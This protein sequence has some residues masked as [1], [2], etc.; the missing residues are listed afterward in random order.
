MHRVDEAEH[1]S[2]ER[3]RVE[4]ELYDVAAR[5]VRAGR[6]MTQRTDEVATNLHEPDGVIAVSNTSV[7]LKEPSRFAGPQPRTPVERVVLRAL[8]VDELDFRA[9][10]DRVRIVLDRERKWND[11]SSGSPGTR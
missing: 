1:A 2:V 7:M 8:D 9:T 3:S 11:A 10:G 5:C 6:S 4:D